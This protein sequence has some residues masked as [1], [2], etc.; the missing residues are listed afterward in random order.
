M[1]GLSILCWLTVVFSMLNVVT[2]QDAL[3]VKKTTDFEITGT[4]DHNAWQK[5]QW[6]P[7]T[8][9]DKGTPY[10]TRI[11]ILYS[12][13]GIYVLFYG[14]DNKITSPFENDFEHL[15]KADVFEV[16]FHP[17]PSTPV[18]FEYEI[19]PLNKELVLLIPNLKG[20]QGWLPW[21]YS[22]NRKVKKNVKIHGGEMK[23]GAA[24][25]SWT[26]ELFFPYA[27]LQPLENT[28]PVSG[29][30]WNANF[31][32]LDYDSGKSIKWSWSPVKT[33]FHE[34]KKFRQLRF[35]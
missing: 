25:T 26:A 33:S 4:G 34:Y 17:Q 8:Q 32:R 14:Q 7:L 18:Y 9:L 24:I 11:K 30:L 22:G 23:N 29:S 19:S 6:L 27:L 1:R 16:F 2:A 3:L 15:F 20:I 10:E 5:T 31:C 13:A 28:P 21:D 35:E 12:D